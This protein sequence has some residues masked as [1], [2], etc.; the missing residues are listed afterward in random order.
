MS[1]QAT[2]LFVMYVGGEG[3]PRAASRFAS[4]NSSPQKSQASSS[5]KAF[6]PTRSTAAMHLNNRHLRGRS[7]LIHV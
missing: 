6:F 3:A 5:Q 4:E 2:D 1:I 7:H